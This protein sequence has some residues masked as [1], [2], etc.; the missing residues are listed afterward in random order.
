VST[1]NPET[2]QT[3]GAEGAIE[4]AVFEEVEVA[5]TP[6]SS[7]PS[8]ASRPA[9]TLRPLEALHGVEL[10][11]TVE[12][13]RARMNLRDLLGV[14]VGSLVELD[15]AAGSPVD[16]LV[17]GVIVARGEVVVVEDEFAVR[18]TELVDSN[19]AQSRN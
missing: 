15:R 14:H 12:L 16:V 7:S 17:S 11:I 5:T 9:A 13:G 8:G 4:D 1:T 19:E 3:G 2:D 10:E 18:V 6:A